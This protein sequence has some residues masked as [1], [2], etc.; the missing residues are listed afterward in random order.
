MLFNASSGQMC[1]VLDQSLWQIWAVLYNTSQDNSPEFNSPFLSAGI[2]PEQSVLSPVPPVAWSALQFADSR[3]QLPRGA[4][5]MKSHSVPQDSETPKWPSEICLFF[6][7]S[8][9][10][11]QT[12]CPNLILEVVE[13]YE[14]AI[15]NGISSFKRKTKTKQTTAKKTPPQNTPPKPKKTLNKHQKSKNPQLPF[16]ICLLHV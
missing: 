12:P 13:T 3:T 15:Y 11:Q 7:I 2:V 16:L 4:Q 10:P 5:K 9:E 1:S 6:S 14:I 8:H